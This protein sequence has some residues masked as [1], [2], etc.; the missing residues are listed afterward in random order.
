MAD[1]NIPNI[2][3]TFGI[4][5]IFNPDTWRLPIYADCDRPV[6]AKR[7][8]ERQWYEEMIAWCDRWSSED[9]RPRIK[10]I[11]HLLLCC[12]KTEAVWKQTSYDRKPM[13]GWQG[14]YV[15]WYAEAVTLEEWCERDLTYSS[16]HRIIRH[17]KDGFG[18]LLKYCYGIDYNAID[19]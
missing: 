3:A 5:P 12:C 16:V 19:V 8:D 6:D 2:E 10:Q 13:I 17:V 14:D 18:R 15:N 1:M 7:W 4:S 9:Y 11:Y